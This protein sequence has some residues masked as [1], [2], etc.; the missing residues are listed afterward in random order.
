ML[1]RESS[2][3]CKSIDLEDEDD[4]CLIELADLESIEG[5]LSDRLGQCRIGDFQGLGWLEL[6]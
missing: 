2:I 4:W 5:S 6:E 1:S 3:V